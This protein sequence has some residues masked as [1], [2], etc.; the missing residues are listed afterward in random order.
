MPFPVSGDFFD[1]RVGLASAS[2]PSGLP[3]ASS[4]VAGL[5]AVL[6]CLEGWN[7]GGVTSFGAASRRWKLGSAAANA[8]I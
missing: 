3:W 1:P 5:R 4:A 8:T 7:E 6:G 2:R